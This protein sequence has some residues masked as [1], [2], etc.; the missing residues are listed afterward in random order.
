MKSN[1]L[2]TKATVDNNESRVEDCEQYEREDEQPDVVERVEIDEL[3][4]EAV[5]KIC[6]FQRVD[7]LSAIVDWH[8][9]QSRLHPARNVV[10]YREESHR[11][12]TCTQRA[13]R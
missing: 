10:R 12:H 2:A 11:R 8:T 9:H 3:V 13:Y 6:A 5:A 7:Q 1:A 4:H